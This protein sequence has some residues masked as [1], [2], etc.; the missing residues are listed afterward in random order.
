[1]GKEFLECSAPFMLLHIVL[2]DKCFIKLDN[3]AG[4]LV[5]DDVFMCGGKNSK[6]KVGECL[7]SCEYIHVQP[8]CIGECVGYY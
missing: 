5:F 6:V 1:M 7:F 3:V 8:V 2:K 4:L